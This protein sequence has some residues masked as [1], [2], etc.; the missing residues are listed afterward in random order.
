MAIDG[1][2]GQQLWVRYTPHEL[3][4][5][6]H[7]GDPLRKPNERTR[8]A[9]RL[10]IMSAKTGTIISWSLVP[11][12][13]ESYYSP[14]LLVHPDS[15]LLIL[16]GTG[17]ETHAGALYAIA[18]D[19][20]LNKRIERSRVIYKDCCKGVMVPPALIDIND[21][22]VLDIVMSLFNSTVIAFDGLEFKELWRAEF[23]TSETY[24]T[25]AVG[26]FNND[27]TP[28][29]V[30]LNNFGPGFPVYYSAQLSVLDGRNGK[31]LLEKPIDMLIGTQ[32]SPLTISTTTTR[33][34]FLFWYS[35]CDSQENDVINASNAQTFQIAPEPDTEQ[36]FAYQPLYQEYQYKRQPYSDNSYD[37]NYDSRPVSYDR[38]FKSRRRY[39]RHVGIHDGGGIQR[40]ISTGTLAPPLSGDKGTIDL[41][42]GTFWFPASK[43]VKLLTQ[44]M[45][46]CI[47]RFMDPREESRQRLESDD[48]YFKR[49][50]FDHDA[51][52]ESVKN[53]C[54]NLYDKRTTISSPADSLANNLVKEMGEMTLYR[55]NLRCVSDQKYGKVGAIKEFDSQWWPSYMGKDADSVVNVND[56]SVD[57]KQ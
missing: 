53:M 9:G 30:V 47:S 24:S 56:V 39:R 7:G 27:T 48:T 29:F 44:E 18:F 16:Y 25:P 45:S 34:L 37:Q 52:E 41:I 49:M 20:L 11:D 36:Q 12:K 31:Q 42:F 1:R 33:D 26:F 3:F 32:S 46:D 2:S 6:I 14:Q 10:L 19:D 23:P 5:I 22:D 4:A 38:I 13:S 55:V 51:Y 57:P 28:D 35:S 21:D 54:T 50:G 15:T 8:L 17:G 43:N 40:V